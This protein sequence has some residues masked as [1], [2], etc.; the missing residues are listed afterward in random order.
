MFEK[1]HNLAWEHLF[2]K[3][4]KILWIEN[5]RSV[6]FPKLLSCKES[7]RPTCEKHLRYSFS[8]PEHLSSRGASPPPCL[9]ASAPRWEDVCGCC[10]GK[11][12]PA[13]GAWGPKPGWGSLSVWARLGRWRGEVKREELPGERGWDWGGGGA[14]TEFQ[15]KRWRLTRTGKERE[16][17]WGGTLFLLCSEW[18]VRPACWRGLPVGMGSSS[19]ASLIFCSPFSS[20]AVSAS[21]STSLPASSSVWVSSLVTVSPGASSV[22]LAV[23]RAWRLVR[24]RGREKGTFPYPNWPGRTLEA[25]QN[26]FKRG[27]NSPGGYSVRNYEVKVREKTVRWDELNINMQPVGCSERAEGCS[28][29]VNDKKQI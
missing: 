17:C 3:G 20:S 14:V 24:C 23:C 1:T 5:H 13:G 22:P 11:M 12:L 26:K 15:S 18:D 2:N 6:S 29:C 4:K 9:L 28:A 10:K 7:A 8:G 16:E 21:L 19:G 25:L 27:K